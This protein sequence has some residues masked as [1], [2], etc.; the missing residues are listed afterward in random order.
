MKIR[1]VRAVA[2]FGIAVVALTGARG[3]HGAG[4]SGG[5][6]SSSSSSSGSSGSS[7][8]TGGSDHDGGS[9][10][11]STTGDGSSSGSSSVSGI[12][13][14]K[15][16]SRPEDDVRIE[17]C[18]FDPS[19]GVVARVSATNKSD[20]ERYTYTFS[21]KFTDPQGALLRESN[22][23]IPWVGP[24]TTDTIDVAASYSPSSGD[25][26]GGK[27]RLTKVSRATAS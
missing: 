8:S 21:V 19:R 7:G 23:T 1:H 4:C 22:S 27:C 6:H 17:S 2:V 5:S 13:G 14:K 12:G 24:G 15:S 16:K 26:S 18:A 20:S 11:G 3:S 10:A 25:G 9:S